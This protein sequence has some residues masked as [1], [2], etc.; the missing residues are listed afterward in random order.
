MKNM[1]ILGVACLA[2]V[3]VSL[4]LSGCSGGTT[5]VIVPPSSTLAT[6]ET[7]NIVAAANAAVSVTPS[8]STVAAGGT[9]DVVININTGMPTRQFQCELN[10]DPAKVQCN[11]VDEGS[12]YQSFV[13]ANGFNE[14]LTPNPLTF[15]NTLGKF[16]AGTDLP[17]IHVYPVGIAM[18]GG[19]AA[20]GSLLGPKGTG[21]VFILHMQAKAGVSGTVPLTL[22]QVAL[23]DNSDPPVNLNATVNNSQITIH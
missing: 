9:F 1:K 3:L 20:D 15:D 10:W 4:L 17:G 6:T 16:P 8:V 11:S 7:S 23:F 2:V 12:F 22:S 14:Y 21:Q 18:M 5:K 13:Q 19:Y